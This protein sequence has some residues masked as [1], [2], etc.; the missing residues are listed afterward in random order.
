[1]VNLKEHWAM[2]LRGYELAEEYRVRDLRNLNQEDW[3]G[4]VHS[5]H[6]VQEPNVWL[7][8]SALNVQRVLKKGGLEF[9]FIG[10]LALQRWGEVRHTNDIDLAV[11]C[12][13]GQERRVV[14][15]LGRTITSR[16][17]DA[18]GMAKVARMYLG[19]SKAGQGVDVS[20]AFM[21][22]ERRMLDRAVDVDFGLERPLHCCSAED[23]V[24]LK[25]VA[26]R[27]QDWV[28]LKRI[29]QRSGRAMD[30]ELVWRELEPLLEMIGRPESMERLRGIVEAER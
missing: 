6:G 30:W 1:M 15:I 29:T 27:G 10:G 16:E 19:R 25:T 13:L 4:Q 18:W 20:L 12:P 23:L 7:F 8:Q 28:D 11:W 5:V 22:Y 17:E 26:A 14:E 9:C 3:L 21:P 24:I 2:K